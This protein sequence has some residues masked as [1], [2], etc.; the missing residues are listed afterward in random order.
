MKRLPAS[1]CATDFQAL[2]FALNRTLFYY[3][4]RGGEHSEKYWGAR[5]WVPM[6]N[7]YPPALTPTVPLSPPPSPH[8]PAVPLDRSMPPLP[9]PTASRRMAFGRPPV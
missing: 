6:T 7:Y 9:L 5:F 8:S 2:G 1:W 3:L 4:D